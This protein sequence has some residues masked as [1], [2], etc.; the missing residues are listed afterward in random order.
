MCVCVSLREDCVELTFFPFDHLASYSYF[1]VVCVPC[2]PLLLRGY[3]C[4]RLGPPAGDGG[5]MRPQCRPA[6]AASLELELHHSLESVC[7]AAQRESRSQAIAQ[8]IP[9]LGLIKKNTRRYIT[10]IIR[11]MYGVKLR[12]CAACSG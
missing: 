7:F 8:Q 1:F 6:A 12:P 3:L 10:I 2:L 11:T 5:C 9:E 4:R